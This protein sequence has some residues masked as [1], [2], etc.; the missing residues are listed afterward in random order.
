M[1][2]ANEARRSHYDFINGLARHMRDARPAIA[3]RRW[4]ALGSL[5]C[6]PPRDVETETRLHPPR[7]R[8]DRQTWPGY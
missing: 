2:I 3:L 7:E 4:S 1:V 6:G 8:H 5:L